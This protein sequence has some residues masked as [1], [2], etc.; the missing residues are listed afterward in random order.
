MKVRHPGVPG[1]AGRT[2]AVVVGNVDFASTVCE[3]TGATP[4]LPQDGASFAGAIDPSFTAPVSKAHLI[5][6][7]ANDTPPRRKSR[8]PKFWG[9]RGPRFKYVEWDSGE[10]E[11]YDLDV[12][13]DEL[14]N[15]A[16]VQ[17]YAQNRQRQH[18]ILALLKQ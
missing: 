8:C 3:L 7:R 17:S 11:L 6:Q 10:V 13:P 16:V 12:D 5:A 2:D 1:P 4:G 15:V 14:T 9:L 18:S